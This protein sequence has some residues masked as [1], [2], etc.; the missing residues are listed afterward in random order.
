ML[1][2]VL[3]TT[4]V[5]TLTRAFISTRGQ[6]EKE[7]DNRWEKERKRREGVVR[8]QRGLFT[9]WSFSGFPFSRGTG[10]RLYVSCTFF[11]LFLC[12]SCFFS[13]CPF[14]LPSL[15]RTL[16][17]LSDL[18][19]SCAR[20]RE[21]ILYHAWLGKRKGTRFAPNFCFNFVNLYIAALLAVCIL[22]VRVTRRC[23]RIVPRPR[24]LMP[25]AASLR[26]DV[27]FG[28]RADT[29][30]IRYYTGIMYRIFHNRGKKLQ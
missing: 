6:E 29:S 18:I 24:S 15:E 27:N 2:A 4:Q 5:C 12:L 22:H 19:P 8:K 30:R 21:S 10:L 11:S 17:R 25:A 1:R 13:V 16:V 26:P 9:R 28:T 3:L 23:A 14:V 7:K 20:E